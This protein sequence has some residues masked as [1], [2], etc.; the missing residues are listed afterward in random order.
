MGRGWG[1]KAPMNK[2]A[3]TSF[4]INQ[5]AAIRWSPRA[6]LDKPVER[7]KL[8]S[9]FE[10]ARWSASGGNEQPWRFIV[11]VDHDETWQKIF[12]CLNEGNKEWNQNV[13]VLIL[14]VGNKISSWD[15][16]ESGYFKYDT[17]Q[18]AAHLSIE[19][20]NQGLHV[21]QMGGFSP[22]KACELFTIPLTHEP[23]T[24][25]AAG[26]AGDPG[27]LPEKLKQRELQERTRKELVEIV[28][29]GKFGNPAFS[30]DGK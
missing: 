17:G 10:A 19:A 26:Y 16:N 28:F 4:P 2:S 9:I 23:L 18:A 6:F 7:E 30:I 15:G 3:T 27:S 20:M 22:E 14:V 24:V 8:I 25:V 13:P 21:H 1:K 5:L 11:G 29:S 12:S